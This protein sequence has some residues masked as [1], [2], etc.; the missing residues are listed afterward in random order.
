MD[1]RPT[2]V[3]M[4]FLLLATLVALPALSGP[5]AAQP[6]D[7]S[8][9][10]FNPSPP[11]QPVKLIF[12][13]HSCGENWL[14]DSNGGL[15]IAL[16]DN[17]YFVSDTYYGWYGGG[18]NIGDR[19]DIGHWWEWFR[20]SS[21]DSI[22][23][24]LYAESDQM[25]SYSR[26]AQDPGGEN[27]IILFKSCYPNS[28]LRTPVDPP[29]TGSNPMRGQWYDWD[30]P[31]YTVA[32]AKGIYNDLLTYFQTRPDKLF[33]AITAPPD[34]PPERAA[35]ARAFNYWLLTEWLREYPLDNVQVWDFYNVLSSNG[36][37]W[38]TNDLGW[39]TGNHHRYHNGTIQYLCTGGINTAAYPDGG[40]DAHPSQAGNL[41]AADEFLPLLNIWYKQWKGNQG[42]PNPTASATSVTQTPTTTATATP[43]STATT[44]A[45]QHTAT[46][47]PTQAAGWH[48]MAFQ[49]GRLPASGYDSAPD[50]IV[51]RD[52][53]DANLGGLERL[54]TFFDEHEKRRSLLRWDLALLPTGARI[55]GATVQLVRYDGDAAS[56]MEVAL[57]RL[58][59][60]WVEGTGSDFWPEEPYTPDGATW[61]NA[62]AYDAWSR[63]G[64]DIDL[65]TDYGCA[66]PGVV[67]QTRILA[68]MTVGL[69]SVDATGA[70]RDWIERGVPNYG[71]ALMPISDE[72]TYH[73]FRSGDYHEPRF[74]PR[75]VISYT[76]GSGPSLPYAII[77]PL[78]LRR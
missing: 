33:I 69:V 5:Q 78:I 34:V 75:L 9:Q 47:T 64:G 46:P 40:S 57:Y 48:V 30:S 32:N 38:Y 68:G 27:E 22:M 23:G 15:G 77:L 50:T 65:V 21:R 8:P 51:S 24:D 12:I 18:T 11:S 1:H 20:G 31:H 62:T 26:L 49:R 39:E 16:R 35:N 72:G 17:N 52:E 45:P 3:G 58:T 66:C 55:E 60:D 54:E 74:R 43:S 13:H 53:P 42:T 36:G 7:V 76:L 41:K 2:M 44:S 59:S 14:A 71:L 63:A 29:T 73:Y 25:V 37:N 70:V 6:A 10:A 28:N 19:T 61:N 4:M 67:G 56:N